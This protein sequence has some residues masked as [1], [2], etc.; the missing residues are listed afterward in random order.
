MV[1]WIS[2]NQGMFIAVIISVALMIWIY[3]CQ[4]RVRSPISDTMVTRPELALEVDT[5]V[6]RIELELDNLIAQAELQFAELDRQDEI[7]RKLFQFAAL[8]AQTGTVNPAGIVTLV[9]TILGGGLLIDNRIKDK[10]IKNRPI[11]NKVI[12]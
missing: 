9:G 8:S 7:K 11:N 2:H 3:G 10:V 1:K 4:S 6:K 5:Q 12:T